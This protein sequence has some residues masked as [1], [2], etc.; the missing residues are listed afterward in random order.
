MKNIINRIQD[1]E[2]KKLISKQSERVNNAVKSLMIWH[3]SQSRKFPALI[4]GS[5]GSS[6][7]FITSSL[8]KGIL[9]EKQVIHT[10]PPSKGSYSDLIESQISRP[11]EM[12][13]ID[14]AHKF[15]FDVETI[16]PHSIGLTI[17]ETF[18]RYDQLIFIS[19]AGLGKNT[20]EDARLET[21]EFGTP[22]RDEII[23]LLVEYEGFSREKATW[24][25]WHSPRNLHDAIKIAKY[26]QTDM[27][28][29][30]NPCGLQNSDL[31][32]LEY[33]RDSEKSC[34]NSI[35][36]CAA[37]LSL[38]NDAIKNSE[39]RLKAEGLLIVGKQ[40]KR[41][42][43]E[44][45]LD[46][47]YTIEQKLKPEPEPEPEPKPKPKPKAKPEAKAKAKA[48]PEPTPTPKPKAKAK[49]KSEPKA[50]P[51]AKV[52]PTSSVSTSYETFRNSIEIPEN[53]LDKLD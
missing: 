44:T 17:G 52:I 43:T 6:K 24:A 16:Q 2:T 13:I 46:L 23:S 8:F 22:E 33:Y 19:H 11:F 27:Q 51:K 42:A 37:K 34:S 26:Y 36:S 29:T 38:D 15:H 48:K 25:A 12:L 32:T 30:I 20:S 39:R 14:E 1:A 28:P 49:A 4:V 45:G 53:P 9:G 47:L 10:I 50:K 41:S 31:K 18:V 5:S 3:E 7:S 35:G 21:I 40:S